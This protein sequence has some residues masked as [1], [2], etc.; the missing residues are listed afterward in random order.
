MAARD[1]KVGEAIGGL[2][3]SC[4]AILLGRNTYQLFAPAWPAM[5]AADDPGAPS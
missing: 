4:S 2:M 5:T 1:A 3:G